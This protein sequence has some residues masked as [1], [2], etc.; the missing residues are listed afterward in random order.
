M[1]SDPV[2]GN[3]FFGRDQALGLLSKRLDALK[4]GYRQNIAILGPRLIGKSSLILQAF[5]SF[6]HSKAIP[7]YVDLRANSFSHFGHKFLGTI[8]Y[9]YLKNKGF[10]VS[11]D[12]KPLKDAACRYIPETTASIEKIENDI[13]NLQF[14]RAYQNLL[15]LT[16]IFKQETGIS[17]IVI[18]DEFHL[19]DTFRIKT[20]LAI[21]AKEIMMQKD[22]MYIVSSS[23]VSYA[24][25]ILAN[26]LSLL[27]GNFEIIRL[28]VFDY[29]TSCKFLERRFPNI[30]LP[31]NLMDFLISFSEGHP[32][33][34]D[35]LSNKVKEKAS[36]LN[37]AEI[38]RFIVTQAFNSLIYDSKGIL[39]QY[40][41]SLL[42][43][44]L[45]GADYSNFLPILL[46]AS[47]KGCK[48]SQIS[49]ATNRHGR[50]I[51]KQINCLL[52]KDLISKIGVFYRIQDKIFRFWLKSVYQRKRISLTADPASESNDFCYEIEKDIQCFSEATK[53]EL[54][55]RVINLFKSFKNETIVVQNKLF[56]FCQFEEV[57]HWTISNLSDCIIARY[58]DGCWAAL[59]KKEGPTE[60]QIQEFAEYCK[61]SKYKIR[62]SIII[63]CQELDLNARLM[64]LDKKIWI[65]QPSDL[66][67]LLDLY[68]KQQVLN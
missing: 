9:H 67:M 37:K 21:L 46:S 64:A 53:K 4:D 5:S 43:H 44:N 45:N 47:T 29:A 58:K 52:E 50:I 10:E 63:S 12:L 24:R 18:F 3:K 26:E 22:T 27:F 54:T 1:F 32:F 23:K 68:G 14:D 2:V 20:P 19:L 25:R 42:S 40:F 13:K 39:N 55:E 35:I 66:N 15:L 62:R 65:W 36:E 30:K 38:D 28:E 11:E 56:K 60:A 57:R 59:V 41:T 6:K 17:C 49:Q 8:L 16:S 61:K 48:L 7:I 51:S 34:L 33:Y 31:K